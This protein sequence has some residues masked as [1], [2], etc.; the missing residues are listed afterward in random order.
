MATSGTSDQTPNDAS[1]ALKCAMDML[2]SLEAWNRER[3]AAGL[4][5]VRV[6]TGVSYGRVIVG[7]IGNEHRL[8]YSD[9]GDVVNVANRLEQLTRSLDTAL[10]VNDELVQVIRAEV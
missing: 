2:A 10:V 4:E 9:I 7:D 6:G 1:N 3:Q 5:K 8:E